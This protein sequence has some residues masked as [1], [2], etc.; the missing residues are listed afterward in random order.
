MINMKK[1]SQ[2]E[3]YVS[4]MLDVARK[5]ERTTTEIDEISSEIK[6][7]KVTAPV[8]GA[9]STGKSAMINTLLGEK[10]L[11]TRIT[12]ETAL[13]AEIVA[14][15]NRIVAYKNDSEQRFDINEFDFENAAK[16]GYI[17]IRVEHCNEFLRSIPDVRLVDMPGL[18][19]SNDVHNK[20]IHDYIGKSLAYIVA[21]PADK[22]AITQ[23]VADFLNELKLRSMP[24][25]FVITKCKSVPAKELE[26]IMES[27][28]EQIRETLGLS[29]VKLYCTNSRGDE[30][31][32]E[33]LKEI[34]QEI[35]KNAD[36][37]F[38][39]YFAEKI[40]VR[41]QSMCAELKAELRATQLCDSDID[42]QI[43]ELNKSLA[44]ASGDIGVAKDK[45]TA[46]AERCAVEAHKKVASALASDKQNLI[47]I[48]KRKG[49]VERR[50]KSTVERCVTSVINNSFM[51]SVK[52][53]AREVA[54]AIDI[55]YIPQADFNND[56]AAET[57]KNLKT[58][59]NTI[60]PLIGGTVGSIIGSAGA[61]MVVPAVASFVSAAGGGEVGAALGA[62]AGPVGIVL[63]AAA[64]LLISG[65]ITRANQ[66]K[67]EAEISAQLDGYIEEISQDVEDNV[68]NELLKY[69]DN[70][71]AEINEQVKRET[72]KTIAALEKAK[73]A[74]KLE[75]EKIVAKQ[76]QLNEDID[77]LR[78]IIDEVQQ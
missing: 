15:N 74:K 66:K 48:I 54:K 24:V 34:L 72:D 17:L 73:Q 31:S 14:G 42:V 77:R 11:P 9:F 21:L 30:K 52:K 3:N 39:T 4:T 26:T 43:E 51:N 49:D 2:Y 59:I 35:Q 40:G 60:A 5:N 53:Y 29:D 78:V 16:N 67:Q 18:D 22:P 10:L 8:I 68:R 69:V 1:Q 6:D 57:I 62:W 55:G 33:G 27:Y 61:G 19:S 44:K 7:F 47:S 75:E 25:Y 12:P 71:D 41:A 32:A 56:E 58:V 70:T 20:A 13:P 50:V 45:L 38:D 36:C 46:D 65:A 64:G 63:G 23:S 37:S 76:A 28:K